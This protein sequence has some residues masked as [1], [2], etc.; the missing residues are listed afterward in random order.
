[1]VIVA[2]LLPVIVAAL[3]PVH[4]NYL[5]IAQEGDHN[6]STGNWHEWRCCSH[7]F[8]VDWQQSYIQC[9]NDKLLIAWD[10]KQPIT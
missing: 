2:A 5:C 10:R 9:G 3:L 8:T 4:I 1:M 6:H 7:Y